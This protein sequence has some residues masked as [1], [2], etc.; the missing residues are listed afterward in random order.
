MRKAADTYLQACLSAFSEVSEKKYGRPFNFRAIEISVGHLRG[1]KP[2]TYTDLQ[3]F[4]SSEHWWFKDYWAFPPQDRI[5]SALKDRR[6]NFW[7]LPKKETQTLLDLLDAF[8]SIELVSIILRF[9]RPE[10]YGIIS[11]P[12]ERVLDVRR[13]SDAGET[14][15]NYT[16]D[17]R[18]IRKAYSLPRVA[19]VDMALWVLHERCFGTLQDSEIK[20]LYFNDLFMLR[21]RAKNLVGPLS[22]LSH[23]QLAQALENV[24]PDLAGLI[25]CYRFEILIREIAQ[26]LKV[27]EL[28]SRLK[29]SEVIDRLANTGKIDS[30]RKGT[31][32][33]LYQIRNGYF[34]EDREPND[35]QRADLIGEVLRIERE[36]PTFQSE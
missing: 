22:Q 13:G 27:V 25:A 18:N 9:V 5:V 16:G 17:L 11:P 34:H 8:K 33:R 23:S 35:K 26:K 14:Y 7:Q 4:E 24:H 3:Y 20:G 12:V 30:L 19:D 32:T 15:L 28:G 1:K 31:W 21:L 2:L 10:H 36:L 6:F 29:L